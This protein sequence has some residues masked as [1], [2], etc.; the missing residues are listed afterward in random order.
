VIRHGQ[1]GP[2]GHKPPSGSRIVPWLMQD[3]AFVAFLLKR[4]DAPMP[5]GKGVRKPYAELH[6]L[7]VMHHLQAFFDPHWV[8][9]LTPEQLVPIR[10]GIA[11]R[12]ADQ[13]AFASKARK[14]ER[15]AA[16][17]ALYGADHYN[18]M[19]RK[20]PDDLP[21]GHY[22]VRHWSTDSSIIERKKKT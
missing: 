14:V 13:V 10:H 1:V 9:S 6:P 18:N 4:K 19:L 8:A 20:L 2:A 16:F 12:L 22:V 5:Y 15:S 7:S 11:D 17:S 3:D 21:P